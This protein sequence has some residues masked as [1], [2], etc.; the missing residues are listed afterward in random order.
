MEDFLIKVEDNMMIYLLNFKSVF[1]LISY[2]VNPIENK[3]THFDQY[4]LTKWCSVDLKFVANRGCK[5]YF[6]RKDMIYNHN[7]YKIKL[8]TL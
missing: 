6:Q 1:N 8:G 7:S 2:A 3:W 5:D 4:S